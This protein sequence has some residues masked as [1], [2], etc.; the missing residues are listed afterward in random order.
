MVLAAAL[1]LAAGCANN[2]GPAAAPSA[3]ARPGGPVV[4]ILPLGDSIT[5]GHDTPGSY[6]T[7][8]WRE[9]T[10]A[11]VRVDFVGSRQNGPDSLPDRDHEG[12]PGLRI[13][14]IDA[15]VTGW[16]RAAAPRFVLLQIGTNDVLQEHDLAG[17]PARMSNLIGHILAAAPGADVY[18]ASLPPLTDRV[19]Q[20]HAAAFNAAL[21]GLVRDRVHLVDLHDRL[22]A[23]D[24]DRDGV[25]QAAGGYAKMA[26]AWAQALRPVVASR[27]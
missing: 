9:L 8:L 3:S 26:G 14:E 21:P 13:D 24:L 4:R 22:T 11:G 6:R 20:E 27:S 10:A 23:A 17:A 16:V 2:A 15:E 19:R 7:E 5:D 12:H 18:V 1:S 25:H